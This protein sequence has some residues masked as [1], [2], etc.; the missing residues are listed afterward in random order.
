MNPFISLQELKKKLSQKE[1]SPQEIL[2]FYAKRIQKF[3]PTLNCILE[4][5]DDVLAS[6]PSFDA[7]KL[8]SGIPCLLK[9]N[10]AQQ[11]RIISAG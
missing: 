6:T 5:F 11:G 1:L 8:L 7:E 2:Q 3:N 10:I 4:T 9:D